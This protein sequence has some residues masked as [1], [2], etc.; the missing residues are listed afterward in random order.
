MSTILHFRLLG[1]FDLTYGD[2]PVA[3]INTPRLQS[4]LAYLVL[5]CDAPQPRQQLAFLLWPDSSE[6][7]ARTNL[8]KLIY[9]LRQALPRADAYLCATVNTLQWRVDAPFTLDVAD[10]ENALAQG[11]LQRA[12]DLYHGDLVPG[13][14][15]DWIAPEREQLQQQYVSVLERLIQ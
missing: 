8:R 11:A 12:V 7:Q 10:F 13:C 9:Q 2:E 6:A 3:T 15:D 4:L 5:H 14:Y 1:G